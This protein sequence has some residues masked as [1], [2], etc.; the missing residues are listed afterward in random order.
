[1]KEGQLAQIPGALI[2]INRP[3]Y[4]ASK[5]LLDVVV[6]MLAM[7]IVA[8]LTALI[9]LCIKLDSPGPILFKQ[10]RVGLNGQPFTLYKFRTMHHNADPEVHR[11]YVEM[12][13]HNQVPAGE[14]G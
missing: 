12:L 10:R 8:P 13:I 6:S 9:A 14:P 7:T 5:R 11:Q 3:I 1:M 2:T 4:F